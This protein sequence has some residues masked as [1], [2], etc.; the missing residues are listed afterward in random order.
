MR[1]KFIL[2]KLG[3]FVKWSFRVLANK[4]ARSCLNIYGDSVIQS[5]KSGKHDKVALFPGRGKTNLRIY[6]WYYL[7]D[8]KHDQKRFICILSLN[9]QE[10]RPLSIFN[11]F[12]QTVTMETMTVT[13]ILTSVLAICFQVL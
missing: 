5:L 4:S 7:P 1:V 9:F 6:S 13:K 2:M 10:M 11:Q 3:T 8:I 12:Y